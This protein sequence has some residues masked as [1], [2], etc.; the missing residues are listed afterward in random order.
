M[1][2]RARRSSEQTACSANSFYE[3][4]HLQKDI[5]WQRNLE[6]SIQSTAALLSAL[7][8]SAAV[9]DTTDVLYVNP[10]YY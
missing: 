1:Q 9:D 3:I 10:K 6:S 8:G 7:E 4:C 5:E 2:R